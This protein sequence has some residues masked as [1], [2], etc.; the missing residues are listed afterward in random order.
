MGHLHDLLTSTGS[1]LHVSCTGAG[2]DFLHR[3]WAQPG[4]SRYLVGAQLP[5][6]ASQLQSFLGFKPSGAAVCE[7]T[8]LH[9]AMESFA[10]A[11]EF[12]VTQASPG[13]PIGL[14]LS[15][16]VASDRLPRGAQRAFVAVVSQAGARVVS[17]QLEKSTGA[18]ARQ[19]HDQTVSELARAVLGHVVSG[20]D[21]AGM[22]A[23]DTAMELFFERPTFNGD[24]TRSHATQ[25]GFYLPATLN[26]IHDGHRSALR[27][28]EYALGRRGTYL[29]TSSSV[30][31]PTLTVP[32]MLQKVGMLRAERWLDHCRGFEFSCDDPLFVDKAEQR[33]GST[34][35]IGADTMQRM[36]DPKWG[37]ETNVVLSRLFAAKARFLVRGRAVDGRFLTCEELATTPMAQ[38]IFRPL[39]GRCDISSTDIRNAA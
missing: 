23:S 13:N 36:L 4:V 1:L 6:G 11:A 33:P 9:M 10:Q 37:P 31:K 14:G 34:F 19:D 38:T 24:G 18:A 8:A 39:E 29:V 25:S 28:A 12:Q 2:I 3:L 5:Y 20:G 21:S 16:A 32:E 22:D 17:V 7:H 35:V 27:S 30:H 15:A 26:P